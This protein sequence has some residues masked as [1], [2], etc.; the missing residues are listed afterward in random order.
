M[1]TSE[2]RYLVAHVERR[3]EEGPHKHTLSMSCMSGQVREYSNEASKLD[4]MVNSTII[5]HREGTTELQTM[6]EVHSHGPWQ[7]EQRV[8]LLMDGIM[9]RPVSHRN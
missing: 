7:D 2:Y 9:S 6:G 8:I 5:F 1:T 3:N 4:G